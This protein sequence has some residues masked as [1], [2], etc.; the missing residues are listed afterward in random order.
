MKKVLT[1]LFVLCAMSAKAQV[2]VGGTGAIGYER[3]TF[4]LGLIP[5]I[6]Y[7]FNEKWAAGA[8]LGFTLLANDGNSTVIGNIEPFVRYTVWQSDRLAFDV[9]GL[10]DMEFNHG[11]C[12]ADLGL[13]PS[14]RFF[15]NKNWDF[16]ADFGL[17]GA[18]YDG[19]DWKPAFFVTGLSVKLGVAYKF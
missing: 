10:A 17:F 15:L 1:L 9:K 16:N 8:G 11:L 18:R 19:N 12:G 6:G 3:E 5:E 7:E 4:Q 14:F 13:R 2:F